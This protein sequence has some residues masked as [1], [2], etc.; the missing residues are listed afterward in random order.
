MEQQILSD[1]RRLAYSL[2]R[3][4]EDIGLSV[5]FLRLEIARGNLRATRAGRRVIVT[6][7]EV[8]RYLSA[9]TVSHNRSAQR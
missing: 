2:A 7:Q 6:R 1:G 3:L 5:G 4:A 8:E 9:N